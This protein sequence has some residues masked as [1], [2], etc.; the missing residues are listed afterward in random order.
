MRFQLS[1][2][3]FGKEFLEVKGKAEQEQFRRDVRLSAHEKASELTVAFENTKSALYLNGTIHS[4]KSTALRSKILESSHSVFC[5]LSAH[6][7]FFIFLRVSGF[8][9]LVPKRAARTILAAVI[10][11]GGNKAGFLP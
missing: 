8:E 2:L 4:Q 5:G 3:Q 7:D 9:T 10:V 6:P 11:R 1:A